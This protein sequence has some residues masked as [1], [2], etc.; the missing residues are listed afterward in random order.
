MGKMC[1]KCNCDEKDCK[2]DHACCVK[3][4]EKRCCPLI[5]LLSALIIAGGLVYIG[6][7]INSWNAQ[8]CKMMEMMKDKK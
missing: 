4:C 6:H 1:E 5:K 8:H 2:C 7:S 3:K